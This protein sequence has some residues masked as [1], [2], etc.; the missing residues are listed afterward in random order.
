MENRVE[1]FKE[2]IEERLF[3]TTDDDVSL[4][5]LIRR[6]VTNQ[7][8]PVLMTYTPYRVSTG[9]GGVDLLDFATYGYVTLIFDV[10]GTG[11]SSGL[12]DS[13]YSDGERRD[14]LFMINWAAS[15]SWS[16]GNVGMWG[17]SYGAVISIQMAAEAP[18]ALKAIIARSGSDDPFAEWTN[19]GGV[20][21]NYIYESYSP[22]MSARNF[23][24]PSYLLWG[25]KW[26][27]I[28][29]E[30][31][32][33]NTPW[34]ISFL[35]EIEDSKF[36]RD[37]AARSNLSKISCPVFVV[38]G[39]SDWY[40]NPMLR[41]FSQ[42]QGVKRALIG[43][44][45]H[46]W[47][48]NALPGPRINWQKEALLWWDKWLKGIDTGIEKTPPL[49]IY[50]EKYRPPGNFIDHS[51]GYFITADQWPIRK[52]KEIKFFFDCTTLRLINSPLGSDTQIEIPYSPKAGQYSGKTGGGPFRYNVLKPGDQ[53]LESQRSITF[54]A[55]V[56]EKKT[57]I[58]GNPKAQLFLS[59]ESDIGQISATLIDQAPNGSE[60]LISRGFINIS[61]A[62]Y[63]EKN[64]TVLEANQIYE[65]NLELHA[66]AY[67]LDPGHRIGLKLAAADFQMSWPA[68]HPFL[69]T[70][71][72]TAE[73][74]PSLTVPYF[75]PN[76]L[77]SETGSDL[78]SIELLI[79][80]QAPVSPPVS[81][82]LIEDLV[83][84]EVGYRFES[85]TVFGN[86]G[87]LRINIDQPGFAEISA[88]S[89]Y[90]ETNGPHRISIE[91][92]CTT[93]SDPFEIWHQ[94][95][96]SVVLD[97]A[98]F[99]RRTYQSRKPRHLF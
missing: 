68:A 80:D 10:R 59:S 94:T 9:L 36:W 86:E 51:P 92:D 33:G 62:D 41:I 70:L 90:E 67:Q 64:P 99:F 76:S 85:Q 35:N 21:R 77:G 6:P 84:N 11:D 78:A 48:N 39:W 96:V 37:R 95:E 88:Q 14:G 25:D 45:G 12:C 72:N 91:A 19:R 47:P 56:N 16:D 24:P 98:E 7:K 26:I 23:A 49:T 15:Q 89:V 60:L 42:L 79:D 22:F 18:P 52:T 27:G 61:Y 29:C 4:A 66:L 30:R 20:P 63:P 40:S 69:L 44:W 32:E 8:L 54:F 55:G 81:Y 65:V 93:A 87:S 31:L 46:Q 74:C 3:V 75:S 53:R 17:L 38:E 2:I 57:L 50:V 71:H 58:I 83:N 34:G 73:F 1:N 5:V 82:Q 97:G 28:W 13:I 43:P